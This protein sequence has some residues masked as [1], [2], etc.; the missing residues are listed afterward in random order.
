MVDDPLLEPLEITCVL[1]DCEILLTTSVTGFLFGIL[2]GQDCLAG[3]PTAGSAR[4]ERKAPKGAPGCLSSAVPCVLLQR[5][6]HPH[7]GLTVPN[8]AGAEAIRRG[9]AD[10]AVES[11][12]KG[13]SKH[14]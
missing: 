3:I 11:A 13:A 12:G 9:I 5:P 14:G 1:P 8:V 10:A 6:E 2:Q 7:Q 4:G